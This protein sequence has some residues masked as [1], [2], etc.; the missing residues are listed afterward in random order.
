M[1]TSW[2]LARPKPALPASY[3]WTWDH[4]TNW[5]LDDPGNLNFGCANAYLKRSETYVEDYRRLTDFAAGLGVKGIVIY[6]F[7]RDCH[8]GVEAAKRVAGYA[9]AKGVAILPGIGLGAYGGT[10]YEG[11]HRYNLPAFLVK[12]PEVQRLDHEGNRDPSGA[13]PSHP[14]YLEWTNESLH[15]LFKEFEVGGANLENGDFQICTC[16]KCKAETATWS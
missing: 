11:D 13:C 3:F 2:N 16:E 9:A 5:M 4:S 12:H 1:T 6:G 8:G 15:W 10:Y 7:L 14:F